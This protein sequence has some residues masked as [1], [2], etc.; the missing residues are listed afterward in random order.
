M[1]VKDILGIT[2]RKPFLDY[3]RCRFF[4][5]CIYPVSQVSGIGVTKVK[6]WADAIG[7]TGQVFFLF[8]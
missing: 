8:F 4:I 3:G 2:L 5:G 1:S 6:V 7:G